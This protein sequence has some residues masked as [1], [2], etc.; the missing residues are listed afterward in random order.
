[1]ENFGLHGKMVKCL[2]LIMITAKRHID[3]QLQMII[4]KLKEVN[5]YQKKQERYHRGCLRHFPITKHMQ[6]LNK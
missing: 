4:E 6:R 1:M 2:E 3:A 5:G